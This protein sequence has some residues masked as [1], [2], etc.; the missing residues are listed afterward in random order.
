VDH[1]A[2][3]RGSPAA[4]SLEEEQALSVRSKIDDATT[5]KHLRMLLGP[6]GMR[7]ITGWV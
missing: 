5:R 2:R 1:A 7:R 4:G 6:L 3:P